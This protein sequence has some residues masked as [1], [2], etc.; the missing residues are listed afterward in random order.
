[1]NYDIMVLN[2]IEKSAWNVDISV[3]NDF[4]GKCDIVTGPE[5]CTARV[6][7]LYS[8]HKGDN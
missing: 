7:E 5:E 6:L 3:P 1:M 2:K 4:D 8:R